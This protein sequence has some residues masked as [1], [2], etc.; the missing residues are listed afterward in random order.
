MRMKHIVWV[1]A[2]AIVF[3]LVLFF[4]TPA[5]GAGDFDR[6]QLLYQARC[7]GL[8]RQERAQ[9]RRAQGGDRGGDSS[10]GEALGRVDGR[11]LE[12]S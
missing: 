3:G 11:C 10:A 9:P 2:A 1:V 12:G 5:V 7:V 8:S 4:F 6:G